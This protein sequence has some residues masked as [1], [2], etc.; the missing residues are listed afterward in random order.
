MLIISGFT[1]TGDDST[2]SKEIK[3]GK[4]DLFL[5]RIHPNKNRWSKNRKK[6]T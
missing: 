1:V 3:E 4:M 2:R 6:Y 5:N